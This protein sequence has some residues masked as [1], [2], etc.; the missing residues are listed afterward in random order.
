MFF[1][2]WGW[3][4]A[5]VV[6]VLG[7]RGGEFFAGQIISGERDPISKIN[8]RDKLERERDPLIQRHHRKKE[9]EGGRGEGKIGNNEIEIHDIRDIE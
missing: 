7:G 2:C 5:S 3:W 4:Q 8:W 6:S 1:S 9:R